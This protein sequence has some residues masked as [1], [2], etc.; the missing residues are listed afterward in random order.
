[1]Y[2][3]TCTHVHARVPYSVY[4]CKRFKA[5]FRKNRSFAQNPLFAPKKATIDN[6]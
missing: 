1:M 5:S 4:A 6:Q 3:R 2:T